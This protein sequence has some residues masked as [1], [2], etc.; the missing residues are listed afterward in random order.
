[1]SSQTEAVRRLGIDY[2][3]IQGPFGGGISTVELLSTVSDRGGLGS[4]GAHILAP[5]EIEQ[6]WGYISA[7]LENRR[8]PGAGLTAS[9]PKTP[10]ETQSG[11]VGGRTLEA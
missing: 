3:I 11:V 9:T 6:L 10:L 4:Y 8:L 7:R 2:P 5:E 1:M